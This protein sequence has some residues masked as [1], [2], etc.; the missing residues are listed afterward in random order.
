MLSSR[1]VQQFR[2][3]AESGRMVAESVA[4]AAICARSMFCAA[5]FGFHPGQPVEVA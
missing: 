3:V 4:N 5:G 2:R 1:H